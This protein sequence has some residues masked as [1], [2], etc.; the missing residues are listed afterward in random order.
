MDPTNPI[1]M[2]QAALNKLADITAIERGTLTEEYRER[3]APNGKGTVRL[4]KTGNGGARR[5]DPLAAGR[6]A[7]VV[8]PI[9]P[10]WRRLI[11]KRG[12]LVVNV[13]LLPEAHSMAGA[14]AQPITLR[15]ASRPRI[16]TVTG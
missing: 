2:R 6:S 14:L 3:P 9:S 12:R 7:T 10:K 15:A 1:T 4:G 16:P 5:L 8:I 11:A 13:W